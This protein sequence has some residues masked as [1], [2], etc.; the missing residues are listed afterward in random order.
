MTAGLNRVYLVGRV[1]AD[2]ELLTALGRSDADLFTASEHRSG[3]A[4]RCA[5]HVST[6]A[7][8]LVAFTARGAELAST[9]IG[10]AFAVEV[11]ARWGEGLVWLD[12]D[13]ITDGVRRTPSNLG[14][15]WL[16]AV[17][18]CTIVRD[19]RIEASS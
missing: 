14:S 15:E 8:Y 13:V 6:D 5:R 3:Y 12:G 16:L 11:V 2:P 9:G 7:A 4:L 19:L 1:G 17:Q 10:G 18:V